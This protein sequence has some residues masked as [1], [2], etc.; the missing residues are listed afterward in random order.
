MKVPAGRPRDGY[1]GVRK[2]AKTEKF[3]GKNLW[4]ATFYDA[5]G[6]RRQSYAPTK[7]EALR[8]FRERTGEAA[9]GIAHPMRGSKAPSLTEFLEEVYLPAHGH[10]ADF[11]GKVGRARLWTK[12]RLGGIPIN[13]IRASQVDTIVSE[14]RA[15]GSAPATINRKLALLRH[16]M[17][18]AVDDQV[19]APTENFATKIKLLREQNKRMRFLNDKE[20]AALFNNLEKRYH[21][22]VTLALHTGMRRGEQWAVRRQ[23]VNL[24]TRTLRVPVSKGGIAREIPLTTSAAEILEN[25]CENVPDPGYLLSKTHGHHEQSGR[26]APDGAK[27]FVRR[28]FNPAVRA[29][30]IVNFRWHD[31]RHT[32]ATRFMA[33]DGSIIELQRIMGHKDVQTTARYAHVRQDRLRSVMERLGESFG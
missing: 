32:F 1:G 26:Y 7:A 10:Q 14:W 27:N 13:K 2:R 17:T 22:L 11:K 19:L 6:K 16:A 31:L 24:E 21:H 18:Y 3:R 5:S 28:W 30:G 33:T 12:S 20:Q 15:G 8:I 29:A 25:L 23:D 9:Q 4:V